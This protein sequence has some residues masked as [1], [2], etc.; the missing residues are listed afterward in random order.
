MWQRGHS[1]PRPSSAGHAGVLSTFSPCAEGLGPFSWQPLFPVRG[2]LPAFRSQDPRCDSQPSR[3]KAGRIL[4]LWEAEGEGGWETWEERGIP[5]GPDHRNLGWGWQL[6][7]LTLETDRLGF[8]PLELRLRMKKG[9]S[10]VS[11]FPR[12]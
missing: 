6:R 11:P 1:A 12:L 2:S 4:L 5:R 8:D 9:N 3:G 10:L 7:G